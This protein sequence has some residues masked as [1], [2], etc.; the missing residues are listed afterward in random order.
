M[1]VKMY[2]RTDDV[3]P[4]RC[5]DA[6]CFGPTLRVLDSYSFPLVPQLSHLFN[7][8]TFSFLISTFSMLIFKFSVFVHVLFL[9]CFRPAARTA[10]QAARLRAQLNGVAADLNK[11][12]AMRFHAEEILRSQGLYSHR[13][14]PH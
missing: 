7:A 12:N 4:F 1:C 3:A 10:W 14:R 13:L 11:S 2:V 6:V 5:F 8:S 9:V